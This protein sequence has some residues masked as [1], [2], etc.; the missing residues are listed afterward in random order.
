MVDEDLTFHP[1]SLYGSILWAATTLGMTEDRFYRKRA[2][3]YREGFPMPDPLNNRRYLKADVRAWVMRRRTIP[4][5]EKE[6]VMVSG[7]SVEVKVDE[8]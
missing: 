7:E 3:L 5:P 2:E 8:L 6:N 4:D 1:Q